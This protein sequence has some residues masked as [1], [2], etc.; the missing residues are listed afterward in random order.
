MTLLEAFAAALGVLAVYLTTRQNPW[1]W[2]LGLVM[3]LLYAWVFFEAR[4]YANTLLQ[5]VFAIT[6]LYGWWQ[7]RRGGVQH[8]GR[9]VS[10]LNTLGISQGLLVGASITLALGFAMSQY[11]NANLPWLDAALTGFSLVAQYWMAQ[12]RL[13]CWL[14]WIV[15]DSIYVAMFITAELYLTAILYVAFTALAV[16]GRL[17]WRTNEAQTV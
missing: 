17:E 3:V 12:K 15:L 9:T 14:L 1:C 16:Y 4:L 7:W 8:Q 10:R 13:Q 11:T 5:G 2:P 6:Q